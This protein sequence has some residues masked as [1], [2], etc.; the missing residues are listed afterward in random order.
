M[1]GGPGPGLDTP[2]SDR[3]LGDK[4]RVRGGGER[5]GPEREREWLNRRLVPGAGRGEEAMRP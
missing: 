1:C 3:D 5:P 4:G 2:A